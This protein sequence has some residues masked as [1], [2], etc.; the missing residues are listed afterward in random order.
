MTV[1]FEVTLENAHLS[2][3]EIQHFQKSIKALFGKGMSDRLK[4][5]FV[6]GTKAAK[7]GRNELY[8]KQFETSVELN[9]DK[10]FKPFL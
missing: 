2:P 8:L 10:T 1:T 9:R 7:P 3:L 6:L 4:H 5:G